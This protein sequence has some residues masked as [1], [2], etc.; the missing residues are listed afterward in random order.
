MNSSHWCDSL[1]G[2]LPVWVLC[3]AGKWWWVSRSTPWLCY[4]PP[5]NPNVDT[6]TYTHHH[7]CSLLQIFP[8]FPAS[9]A[10]V[11]PAGTFLLRSC[12]ISLCFRSLLPCFH[13][14]SFSITLFACSSLPHCL[15]YLLSSLHRWPATLHQTQHDTWSGQSDSSCVQTL[16]KPSRCSFIIKQSTIMSEIFIVYLRNEQVFCDL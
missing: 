13:C 10:P 14:H 7:Y 1:W 3:W 6:H 9:W 15:C 12:H 4:A 16:V 8:C 5:P 2:L 11:L